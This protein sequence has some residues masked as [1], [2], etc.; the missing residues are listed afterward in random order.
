V[1]GAIYGRRGLEMKHHDENGKI[2]PAQ[3]VVAKSMRARKEHKIEKVRATQP[4]H[5]DE[6]W[7]DVEKSGGYRKGLAKGLKRTEKHRQE[8]RSKSR[9]EGKNWMSGYKLWGGK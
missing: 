3:S 2:S 9:A 5:T 8:A 7:K 4:K 1:V 6:G